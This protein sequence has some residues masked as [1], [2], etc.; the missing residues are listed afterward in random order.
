M[1]P[2]RTVLDLD[3][4]QK[5]IFYIIFHFDAIFRSALIVHMLHAHCSGSNFQ[6]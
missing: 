6:V 1:N 4:D 3:P 2:P 5:G